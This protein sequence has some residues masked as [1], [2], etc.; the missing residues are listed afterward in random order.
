MR[1]L[2]FLDAATV[3][4]KAANLLRFHRALSAL[5]GD[6][7]EPAV[8]LTVAT[9]Q[10]GRGAAANRELR[11]AADAAGIPTIAIPERFRFDVRVVARMREAADAVQPHVVQTHTVKSHLLVQLAGIPRARPWI[12][13]HHGYTWPDAKM[14]A[15]NQCDRIS[16][17]AADRVVT[18]TQAFVAEL[19]ARGVARHRVV[20]LHNAFEIASDF[21]VR[22]A[23]DRQRLRESLGI[24]RHERVVVCIGRLSKEKGHADLVDA[25]A[26]LR[27]HAPALPIRVVV[28][29]DG[30]ERHTLAT[31]ARGA[32]VADTIRWLGYM[33]HAQQLYAAADAAVLPSHSE[34]SPNALL[35][36]AAYRLPI[37]ATTVGGVREILTHRQSGL[38]VPARRPAALASA[39]REIFLDSLHA[40]EM[41][42]HA[43]RVVEL[44]HHPLAR[45]Q[46]LVALYGEV[47]RPPAFAAAGARACA[48]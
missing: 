20:V 5:S 14:V 28:A 21:D 12:A 1:V 31:R 45:A 40:A 9:F 47:L 41:G 38:L 39:L 11:A 8:Q 25:I 32:G 48:Y 13:F 10:R 16:L 26:I 6:G 29:G 43:R 3:T 7:R 24:G 36:A 30:P 4:G 42:W 35:E 27:A 18:P 22:A 17:R 34:G 19:E 46:A 2:A 44:R 37:V 23:A 15:Y 33:S